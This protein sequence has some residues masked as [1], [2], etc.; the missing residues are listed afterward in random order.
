MPAHDHRKKFRNFNRLALLICTCNRLRATDPRGIS[1]GAPTKQTGGSNMTGFSLRRRIV[2]SSGL[3]LA[4]VLLAGGA[5]AQDAPGAVY[6]M[7]NAAG[8]NSILIFARAAN[9][10]LTSAGSAATGGT[11]KGAGLGSQGALVVTND[12]R[13]LLAVNAGSNDITVFSV[14]PDGL[15]WRSKTPSDGAMPISVAIHGRLVFV[16]NA[17]TPNVVGFRLSNDGTLYPLPGSTQLVSGA[18]GP[19]EVAFNADGELLIVTDKP[20][21]QVFTLRVNDEGAAA[22]PVAHVSNGATPFGFAVDQRDHLVV[23]EAH[24]GPNGASALS[25]YDIHEEGGLRLITGSAPTHQGAACWVVITQNDKF[26]YT[27]DTASGVITG[28]SL[29]RD[30]SLT[31]LDAQGVSAVTGAGSTPT[32]LALSENSR[33]LFSLN[34]GAGTVAGWRIGSDGALTFTGVATGM[35]PSATGIAAR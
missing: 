15:Q 31:I 10:T 12:Q 14:T 1:L 13:W 19:A 33:F 11:G 24:G 16:L 26:A 20:T 9:G 6:G 3:V 5:F 22:A 17:G 32:D 4:A 23:S 27:S 34:L 21:N 28:F 25:S 35:P 7:T 2:T 29:S 30:G 8:G 18:A